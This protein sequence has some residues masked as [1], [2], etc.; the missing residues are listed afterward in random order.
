V[1]AILRLFVCGLAIGIAVVLPAISGGTFAIMFGVY[2]RLLELITLDVKKIFREWRFLAPLGIGVLASIFLFSKLMEPLFAYFPAPASWFFMG[3][4]A[5]SLPMLYKKGG[6]FGFSAWMCCFVAL[7]AMVI[8]V[9][10]GNPFSPNMADAPESFGPLSLPLFAAI[11]ASVALGTFALIIPGLSG[12]N[13]LIVFG[14][15]RPILNAVNTLR[16]GV[17][18]PAV[19]GGLVG[20]LVGAKLVR[21]LLRRFGAQ[22]Y[23]AILGLVAGSLAMIFPGSL[24]PGLQ[25][26]ASVL[27]FIA[28]CFL[29]GKLGD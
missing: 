8:P 28:G 22:T 16:L 25:W 9:I 10:M 6:L 23:G 7:A 2:D 29:T 17:L 14:V 26:I 24:G 21:L 5:G 1:S 4:I 20:L 11:A 19:L 3:L 27:C 13:V 15:Y 18:L 12:S